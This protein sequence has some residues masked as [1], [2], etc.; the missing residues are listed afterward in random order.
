MPARYT[1]HG[2]FASGPT[3]KVGLMLSLA[4]EPFDYV[5]SPGICWSGLRMNRSG[6]EVQRLQMN[7]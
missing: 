4:G 3:Y 6:S 2:I 1:L 7:S 5:F